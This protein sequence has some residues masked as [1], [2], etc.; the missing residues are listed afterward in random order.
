VVTER[1]GE[2]HVDLAAIRADDAL[3]DALGRGE[4][5]P[6]GDDLAG[7]VVAW[8]AELA[9]DPPSDALEPPAHGTAVRPVPVRRRATGF[10]RALAGAVA[11]AAV[12]GGVTLGAQ[13]SGPDSPLWPITRVL[14]PQRA[15]VREAEH[16]IGLARDAAAAGRYDEARRLLDVAA[17]QAETV[18]DP[19]SRQRLR[20]RI[21]ELRRSLPA[22]TG[23][24][25]ATSPTPPTAPGTRAP[26]APP[27]PARSPGRTTTAPTPGAA[28]RPPAPADPL[29]GLESLQ[30]SIPV[31]KLPVPKLPVPKLPVPKLPVPKLPVPTLPPPLHLSSLSGIGG[32][33]PGPSGGTTMTWRVPTTS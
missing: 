2:Q 33:G 16:A 29:P 1:S 6:S 19:A 14:Y 31:P 4:P 18:T 21:D 23:P 5:A 27:T 32:L 26:A 9:T 3:L 8:R 28:G 20:D 13:R 11:A 7:L 24:V 22:G 12:L 10:R 15:D 25:G 17:A 30:P